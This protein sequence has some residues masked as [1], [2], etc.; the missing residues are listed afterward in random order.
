METQDIIYKKFIL[1]NCLN[2]HTYR[3]F[4]S[5]RTVILC[6][7]FSCS[8]KIFKFFQKLVSK[9]HLSIECWCGKRDRT[10]FHSRQGG[11]VMMKPTTFENA[12]R[13]QF[14]TLVKRVIDTTV[15]DYDRHMKFLSDHEKSF[16]ELPEIK[17]NSF[18]IQDD[19]EMDVT[20]FD[21]YGM[22]ARVSG[23]ELCKALK[24]LPEKKRNN[25]LMFYFLDMSDTEIAELQKISRAGAF[26]NRQN[27]LNK[28]RELLQKSETE[29]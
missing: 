4:S 24:R 8:K 9:S 26:K 29:E 11:G 13:L 25:L 27:A 6:G 17:V 2:N 16:C 23:D 15:K 18:A 12:I 22:E 19:Y 20:V 1:S 28:M 10:I 5:Y 7:L 21:V 3:I 14:D